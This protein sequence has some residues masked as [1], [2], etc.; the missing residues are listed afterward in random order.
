MRYELNAI[1]T[2]D[3][4]NEDYEVLRLLRK[5]LEKHNNNIFSSFNIAF[6]P[7]KEIE[8]IMTKNPKWAV[9]AELYD[10]IEGTTV[11]VENSGKLFNMSNVGKVIVALAVIWYVTKNIFH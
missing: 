3:D 5:I 7:T 10:K 11:L 2:G 9:P 6:D 4:Y 8:E 1:N